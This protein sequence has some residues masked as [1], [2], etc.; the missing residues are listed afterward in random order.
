M[1][2]SNQVVRAAVGRLARP[3][4]APPPRNLFPIYGELMDADERGDAVALAGLGWTLFAMASAD[5]QAHHEA[6]D[7]LNEL[8]TA[9]RAAIAGA[10]SPAS[11]AL[12]QHVLAKHGW[13]PPPDAT[14][15]QMVAEPPRFP[16]ERH[17]DTC[18]LSCSLARK[19]VAS[20]EASCAAS[21]LPAA[22]SASLTNVSACAS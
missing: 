16:C 6:A 20:A 19:A 9:A 13:L 22:E 1:H 11:L 21:V 2:G 17:Y 3:V 18:L 12:L 14:P 7:L 15:L 5:R 4:T 8:R 10:G